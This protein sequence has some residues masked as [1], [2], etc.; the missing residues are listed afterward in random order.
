MLPLMVDNTL[1]F[2]KSA[3]E[4]KISRPQ[5]IPNHAPPG[6]FFLPARL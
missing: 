3:R 6:A 4:A 2:F 1:S 5:I